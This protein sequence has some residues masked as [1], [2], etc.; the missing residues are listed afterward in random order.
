MVSWVPPFTAFSPVALRRACWLDAVVEGVLI[1]CFYGNRFYQEWGA[2]PTFGQRFLCAGTSALR[3]LLPP[4][5]PQTPP[6][7]DAYFMRA[8]VA[9][10]QCVGGLPVKACG[11]YPAEEYLYVKVTAVPLRVIRI[12]NLIC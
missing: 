4:R 2:D 1:L 9:R 8:T 7:V 11:A 12:S 5:E 3:A 6:G 10:L